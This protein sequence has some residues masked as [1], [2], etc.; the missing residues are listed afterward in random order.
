M[1]EAAT[2]R[3]IAYRAFL[4]W[5]ADEQLREA[6]QRGNLYGDLALG[7]AFDGGELEGNPQAFASG[8]SIGAP[9]DPFSAAGQVWNL[10]PFSPL[11]LA[12]EAMAPMRRVM[13]AN[14][15]H[16]AALRIDHVLGFARQFWV[17]RGA[18]GRHG[19][20]VQ[21]PLDALI[22]VTA[23]ESRRNRCLVVGE[24]LGTVPEGLRDRLSAAGIL[25]YRVLW[26]ERAG[27]GFKPADAYPAQALACL[28]S[29]DL[30]TFMGWRAGRDIAIA[31]TL[32]HIDAARAEE[33]MQARAEEERLLAQ[34]TGAPGEDAAADSAATHGFVARTPSRIM[35]VQAD[36][37]AGEVD[38]LNVPGTDQEWPNWRRRVHVPVEALAEGPLA[39]GI[40]AA[41]K[42][43]REA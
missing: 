6:A 34:R 36:D 27:A 12:A 4:Q 1:G 35:L 7:C 2:P 25:S 43:E 13:A 40:I 28:A 14:M 3:R 26:F 22:A 30:P 21:F 32:G 17:P 18:E 10:P 41:V 9:P 29:H 39:Q 19:A 15:R 31:E 38:P 23:I 5:V 20:Y 42:Q 16:A 33:Q 37:M 8:V 24:D 11:A